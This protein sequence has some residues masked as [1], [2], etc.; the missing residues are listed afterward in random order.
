MPKTG[1]IQSRNTHRN[2]SDE[3]EP[4]SS[5][6]TGRIQKGNSLPKKSGGI[7]REGNRL[8]AY[9]FI[10]EHQK[11]FGI[12]WLLNQLDIYPNAYYNYRK[13]RKVDYYAHKEEVKSEIEKIY[14]EHNG[15][16]GY[17]SMT[18]YLSR[19][20][21]AYSTTTIHKDMN[22]EMGLCSIVRPK[23]PDYKPGTPHKVFENKL[24][25]DFT[26]ECPN[27][28]WCT[29]FTYLFLKNHD[30]LLCS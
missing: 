24:N 9:R 8:E 3:R 25:Q 6:R 16:D 12:R 22:V 15:V 30:N 14:H 21:Y 27:Q 13:K 5:E 2:R 19:R 4:S 10:D 28:K 29:D 20:G 17:R 18:V 11:E 26:A 23:K 7:L 1:P